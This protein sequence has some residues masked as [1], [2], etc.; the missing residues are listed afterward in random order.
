MPSI[1]PSRS[2]HQLAS[3]A[4]MDLLDLLT[5]ESSSLGPLS[6]G[7]P[8]SHSHV[9]QG[10]K[11]RKPQRESPFD[12]LMITAVLA[13]S[14][15]LSRHHIGHGAARP[16]TYASCDASI[17]ATPTTPALIR[18]SCQAPRSERLRLAQEEA[19]KA[20]SHDQAP[21]ATSPEPNKPRRKMSI[22][23]TSVTQILQNASPLSTNYLHSTISTLS[24][25]GGP[26]ARPQ[27]R[28]MARTR[29]PTPHGEIF[30]HLYHNSE[31]QKEHLAIVIDPIQLS[32]D[33]R[34]AAPRGR[35]EIRSRSLDAKWRE[36]ETDLERVVRGAYVG[37]LVPGGEGQA[38]S[39]R[40][41][42]IPEDDE[43]L[44]DD[45]LPLVRI[46]SECFTGETIGSMRCDCGEQL[47]EAL[48]LIA[49]SQP[50]PSSL[51]AD[52]KTSALPTPISSRAPSPSS[53]LYST[54]SL[55]PGRGVVI[56][57]RQEGRGIGLLEKIR[58]YNLQDLG[59]D[60]VTANLMLGHG[61]DERKYGVAAEIL[62]DL[63]LESGLRLLT[64]NPEKVEGMA[65]ENI[66][67]VERVGMVP[68]DWKCG[69]SDS[70][71]QEE[72]YE[73][74]RMRRGGVGLIGAG[75]AS[76]P[77]L[78]KYLRTKVER[79]GHSEFPGRRPRGTWIDDEVQ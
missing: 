45:I 14:G 31:D 39:S 74:W 15:P 23:P 63:G 65:K 36:G 13:G 28:C 6:S 30:L 41:S 21:H 79:M 7:P 68:R 78:E 34:E 25:Q 55:V 32:H 16:G 26:S 11:K 18:K 5:S 2:N 27:V 43:E 35:K 70:R 52:Q 44:P 73:D 75:K 54:S 1:L 12:P 72:E 69:D 64:N 50:L 56:Y 10:P 47:D 19:K 29:V 20:A 58:A 61:A 59:H 62:R 38:S 22:D 4:D 40:E 3:Q 57:M 67:I 46:H 77:E 9:H 42:S 17:P 33:A 51:Q 71:D 66:K 8:Q 60:T 53:T 76:G 49:Q 37:R 24:S 48:R